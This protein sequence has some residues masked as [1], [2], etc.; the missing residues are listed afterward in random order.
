MDLKKYTRNFSHYT[1]LRVQ[2]NRSVN[3]TLLG[4]NVAVNDHKS[5]KGMSARVYKNGS[6]GFASMPGN[7]ENVENLISMAHANGSFLARKRETSSIRLPCMPSDTHCNFS[8]KKSRYSQKELIEFLRELDGYLQKYKNLSGRV[9]GVHL[10]DMERTVRTS[11]GS[12]FFSLL[13]KSH[14]RVLLSTEKNGEKTDLRSAYGGLGHMEDVHE[15]PSHCFEQLD[16]LYENLMKKADGVIPRAGYHDVVLH[17]DLAGILAHEAI[18]HTTE[19]DLVLAGSVAGDFLN[20]QVASPLVSLVDFAHTA[21]GETCPVPVY[22]D[23]EGTQAKDVVIIEDGMLKG[24]MHSK[25]SALMMNQS[26]TGN[27]RAWGFNDEPLVRMRNTAILPGKSRPEDMLASVDDGYYL[28]MPANGQADS[29][30][31]FMFAVTMGYEIKK[32]KLGRPIKD[33]TISGV[34][35]DMLKTVSMVSNDMHWE[36]SGFCG[37]GQLMSVS[38]GGPAIKCR[39]HLGGR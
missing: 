19:A 15:S 4:G 16:M 32:G 35:F 1:E 30:S 8:T 21:F 37:K 11:D 38:M 33:T 14:I 5:V 23:D 10:L 20:R 28:M 25:E 6:W 24:Y 7:V 9:V 2:E 36:S 13:P 31:E 26:P 3:I 17:P 12:C 22:T 18:G 27:A 29:T 34:A 39:V